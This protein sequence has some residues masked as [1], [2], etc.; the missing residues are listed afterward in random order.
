[1]LKSSTLILYTFWLFAMV[2]CENRGQAQHRERP[3]RRHCAKNKADT[4]IYKSQ[5][6]YRDAYFSVLFRDAK[7]SLTKT[8]NLTW[9]VFDSL[10]MTDCVVPSDSIP[11]IDPTRKRIAFCLSS[12]GDSLWQ[13]LNDSRFYPQKCYPAFISIRLKI[14]KKERRRIK[15]K[16]PN[17]SP[18]FPFELLIN[19]RCLGVGIINVYP[20]ERKDPQ[21]KAIKR[22]LAKE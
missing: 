15:K 10:T 1:M 11:Y 8:F 5:V 14:S 20:Y 4:L 9:K 21:A 6:V 13:H 17:I 16:I 2:V 3:P 22:F 12:E 19:R 18:C 7:D